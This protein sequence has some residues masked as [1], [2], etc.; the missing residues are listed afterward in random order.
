MPRNAIVSAMANRQSAQVTRC[1]SIAARAGRVEQTIGVFGELFGVGTVPATLRSPASAGGTSPP[2]RPFSRSRRSCSRS[3]APVHRH[4]PTPVASTLRRP[5][6]GCRHRRSLHDQFL[7]KRRQHN[8]LTNSEFTFLRVQSSVNDGLSNILHRRGVDAL[9]LEP[10]RSFPSSR[11]FA[12]I[13]RLLPPAAAWRRCPRPFGHPRIAA[14]GSAD[15]PGASPAITLW[16]ARETRAANSCD[17]SSFTSSSAEAEHPRTRHL[18]ARP[19]THRR[20]ARA[21]SSAASRASSS[22]LTVSP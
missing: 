11:F 6:R 4:S 8:S 22:R 7:A 13:Q 15:P 12:A 9:G 17:R 19:P 3:G 16:S 21:G 14:G 1:A 18:P 5:A 2:S 20:G 10:P